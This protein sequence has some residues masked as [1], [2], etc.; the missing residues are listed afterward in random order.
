M[1]ITVP[2]ARARLLRVG[3]SWCD[4][5][6]GFNAT[7][8]NSP[9]ETAA[10]F[11]SVAAARYFDGVAVTNARV[12]APGV[13]TL[14]TH[15]KTNGVVA[16]WRVVVDKLGVRQASWK[17]TQ[18]AVAPFEA[19]LHGPT[20]FPGATMDYQRAANGLVAAV[21]DPF[22][23]AST[24][25]TAP[26]EV[27]TSVIEMS[28]G[29][30]VVVSRGHAPYVY[31][32]QRSGV[33][34]ID[35]NELAVRTAKKNYED[36]LS[37]GLEGGWNGPGH[38]FIDGGVSPYCAACVFAE[39]TTKVFNVHMLSTISDWAAD[40]G[41]TYPDPELFFSTVMGH[42][43]FHNFQVAN[44]SHEFGTAFVEGTARFQETLHDYSSVSHQPGSLVNAGND[45]GCNGYTEMMSAPLSYHWYDA[46]FAWMSMY[47]DHGL[48][49]LVALVQS[50]SYSMSLE[51]AVAAATGEPFQTTISRVA[52]RALTGEDM[53]WGPAVG[54]GPEL[55]WSKDLLRWTPGPMTAANRTMSPGAI[56]GGTIAGSTSVA[57][58]AAGPTAFTL[59]RSGPAGTSAAS[60]A[61][62]A[63]VDGPGAGEKLWLVAANGASASSV[64]MTVGTPGPGPVPS[65]PEWIQHYAS[66]YKSAL[67]PTDTAYA[68]AT[69]DLATRAF[70]LTAGV[71]GT[72][73]SYYA[74]PRADAY[75]YLDGVATVEAGSYE[76]VAI[77]DL[78]SLQLTGT[79]GTVGG[80]Y[81]TARVGMSI[82]CT[83]SP[84]C[85]ES[86]SWYTYSDEAPTEVR[87]IVLRGNLE[88]A[89]PQQLDIS[90]N[91]T[92]YAYSSDKSSSVAMKG[93]IT[94]FRMTRTA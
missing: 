55:D 39:P 31:T 92:G 53:V 11:A 41:Y 93:R 82:F 36:F 46:C 59:V 83:T 69:A 70:D 43:I 86:E 73:T 47:A 54:D 30:R 20:A 85:Y 16:D 72:T 32:T 14:V 89:Q 87:R 6:T 25:A 7:K 94:D 48:D 38:V 52:L 91:A 56:I 80:A 22:A 24:A 21:S 65:A 3:D 8:A 78:D 50:D 62:G 61:D 40:L 4:G 9:V 19:S 33:D 76:F 34:A 44:G 5:L 71:T 77:F 57:L 23:A 66:A 17:A 51:D 79:R 49:A 90:L 35:V 2:G 29:F 84:Y 26:P 88:L 64:Q 18:F 63:Q 45:S 67:Q 1:P 75:S 13:V 68:T 10:A 42:E 37:W 81:S 60:V 58:T 12:V 74:G 28:D 27:G 15:A